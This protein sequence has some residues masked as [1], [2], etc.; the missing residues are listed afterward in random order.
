M[1]FAKLVNVV[2]PKTETLAA[3]FRLYPIQLGVWSIVK[4]KSTEST[5]YVVAVGERTAIVGDELINVIFC[6]PVV[7]QLLLVSLAQ[8]CHCTTA[9]TVEL[10]VIVVL[11]VFGLEP[12]AVQEALA[13]VPVLLCPMMYPPGVAKPVSSVQV[14]LSWQDAPASDVLVETLEYVGAVVSS[15]PMYASAITAQSQ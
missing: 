3:P 6:K 2:L 9:P 13:N 5:V 12:K 4:F 8:T 15:G 7:F 14:L 10:R 1:P 11:V